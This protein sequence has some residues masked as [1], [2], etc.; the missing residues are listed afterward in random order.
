MGGTWGR[1]GAGV[2]CYMDEVPTKRSVEMT[3][4]VVN[5]PSKQKEMKQHAEQNFVKSIEKK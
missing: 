3:G 1:E 2:L 4:S 5:R